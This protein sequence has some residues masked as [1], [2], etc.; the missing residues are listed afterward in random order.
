MP[1][2]HSGHGVFYHWTITVF[3][4]RSKVALLIKQELGDRGCIWPAFAALL[5]GHGAHSLA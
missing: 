5:H 4:S 1:V 2:T 3:T